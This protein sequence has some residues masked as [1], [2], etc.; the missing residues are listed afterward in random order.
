[1]V[2]IGTLFAFVLVCLGVWILRH[3]DPGANRPFRTPLVPLV[4]ILGVAFCGYL[5]IS[6]PLIT[7]IRFFGWMAIGL[8]IYF[9]YGRHHSKVRA[10]SSNTGFQAAD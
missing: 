10:E 8:A 7:W 2:N 6:L 5:M 4:P 3:I 9:L 1:L